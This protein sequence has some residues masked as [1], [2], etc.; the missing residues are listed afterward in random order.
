MLLLRDDEGNG[1]DRGKEAM[2][3]W[4]QAA[5]PVLSGMEAWSV[6]LSFLKTMLPSCRTDDTTFNMAEAG[7]EGIR[8]SVN[9]WV[10]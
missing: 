8:H 10:L 7:R 4:V 1:E 9:A 6:F 5:V 2:E 3:N